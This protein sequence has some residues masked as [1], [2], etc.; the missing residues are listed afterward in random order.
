MEEFFNSLSPRRLRSP[1]GSFLFTYYWYILIFKSWIT[2]ISD[3]GFPLL[4]IAALIVILLVHTAAKSELLSLGSSM[5]VPRMTILLV[6][7]ALILILSLIALKVFSSGLLI[8]HMDTQS[9]L[10]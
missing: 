9:A 7:V 10:L 6:V 5:K 2:S 3:L 1:A 8:S 4:L